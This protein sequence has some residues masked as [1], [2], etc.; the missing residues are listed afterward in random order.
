M[1]RSL[2]S[3]VKTGFVDLS[4]DKKF[5]ISQADSRVLDA[6]ENG[7]SLRNKKLILKTQNP[8]QFPWKRQRADLILMRKFLTE[9]RNQNEDAYFSIAP[10]QD[11]SLNS[12]DLFLNFNK[13]PNGKAQVIG[14]THGFGSNRHLFVNHGDVL[15]TLQN[16]PL[17]MKLVTIN[18]LGSDAKIQG[19]LTFVLRENRFG[20]V[21]LLHVMHSYLVE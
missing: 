9:I 5:M 7:N 11:I 13:T 18:T 14:V 8:L 3:S 1:I 20:R 21:N 16:L 19:I 17:G 6:F 12:L 4:A 10:Y 15:Q 2:F